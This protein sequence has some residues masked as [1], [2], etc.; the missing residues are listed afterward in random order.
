MAA[1][2]T[3]RC[4][5]SENRGEKHIEKTIEVYSGIVIMCFENHRQVWNRFGGFRLR[6]RCGGWHAGQIGCLRQ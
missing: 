6:A 4:D 3:H 5:S 2:H 1:M